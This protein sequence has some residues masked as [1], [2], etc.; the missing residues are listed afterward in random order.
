[1]VR[2]PPLV[3]ELVHNF[4]KLKKMFQTQKRVTEL[5]RRAS[6]ARDQDQ[7]SAS[8]LKS[9]EDKLKNAFLQEL[10]AV[11]SLLLEKVLAAME[12]AQE[13]METAEENLSGPWTL[14]AGIS[15]AREMVGIITYVIQAISQTRPS[16]ASEIRRCANALEN[17]QRSD[18][19]SVL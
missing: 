15:I 7:E 10:V 3:E 19:H 14:R 5:A 9:L 12:R 4:N 1:M 17:V 16:M 2:L 18:S 11:G 8:K 13:P 6:A